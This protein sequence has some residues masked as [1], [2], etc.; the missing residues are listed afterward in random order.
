LGK[1]KDKRQ[2]GSADRGGKERRNHRCRTKEA[3]PI[4]ESSMGSKTKSPLS[5]KN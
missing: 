2:K 4:D 5:D 3:F 1:A